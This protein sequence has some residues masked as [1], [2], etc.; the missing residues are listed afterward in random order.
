MK[1]GVEYHTLVCQEVF[2]KL[3]IIVIFILSA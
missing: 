2:C 1:V 3:E